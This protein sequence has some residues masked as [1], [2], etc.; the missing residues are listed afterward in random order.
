MGPFLGGNRPLGVGSMRGHLKYI[1]LALTFGI[2]SAIS[3]YLGFL[4]GSWLDRRLGT[5]PWLMFLGV[6]LGIV[7]SFRVMLRETLAAVEPPR[8]DDGEKGRS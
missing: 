2:T 4:G 7:T 6:I 1:N 8:K 5:N 3:I